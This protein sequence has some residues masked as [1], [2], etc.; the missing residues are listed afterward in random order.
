MVPVYEHFPSAR[1]EAF[2]QLSQRFLVELLLDRVSVYVGADYPAYSCNL[3]DTLAV[4][5]R[6]A[7][8]HVCYVFLHIKRFLMLEYYSY[9]ARYG[10]MNLPAPAKAMAVA[11]ANSI[12]FSAIWRRFWDSD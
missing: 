3:H 1:V 7:Q 9:C 4:V 12:A 5:D 2:G 10:D 8:L 11:V 6:V